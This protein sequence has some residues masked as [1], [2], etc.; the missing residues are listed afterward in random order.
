MVLCPDLV[1]GKRAD[2]RSAFI[3]AIATELQTDLERYLH[4][5]VPDSSSTPPAFRLDSDSIELPSTPGVPML[6][7]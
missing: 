2:G 3:D 7:G 6:K 5:D 4:Y 1:A